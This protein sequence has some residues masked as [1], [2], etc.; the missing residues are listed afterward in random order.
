MQQNV[1]IKAF[2]KAKENYQEKSF[3][4]TAKAKIYVNIKQKQAS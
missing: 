2:K 4:K 3:F 1:K